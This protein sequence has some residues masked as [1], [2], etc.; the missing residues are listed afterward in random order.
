[1]TGTVI[2]SPE[3]SAIPHFYAGFAGLKSFKKDNIWAGF[4]QRLEAPAKFIF[5]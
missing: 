5:C 1:M 2:A 4:L 3:E